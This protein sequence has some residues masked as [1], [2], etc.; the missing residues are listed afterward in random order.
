MQ[1]LLSTRLQGSAFTG[2]SLLVFCF[3]CV[4][5]CVGSNLSYADIYRWKDPQGTIH[6]SNTPPED[7]SQILDVIPTRRVPLVQDTEGTVYYLN[8]PDGKFTKD[9]SFQ[10]MLDQL[11]LPEDVLEGL[12]QEAAAAP[13]ND[14]EDENYTTLTF[15]MAEL[16][17]AL[18]REITKRLEWKQEYLKSQSYTQQLEQH[19]GELTLAMEQMELDIEKLQKAVNLSEIHL[20]ALRNPQQ[21]L[22]QLENKL[23]ELQ[24]SLIQRNSNDD[25]VALRDKLVQLQANVTDISQQT[26][27]YQDFSEQFNTLTQKI[28]RLEQQQQ[29]PD[30]RVSVK[31][32]GLETEVQQLAERLPTL[33]NTDMQEK[34]VLL[35]AYVTDIGQQTFQSVKTLDTTQADQ[36]QQVA[37]LSAKIS[38]LETEMKADDERQMY[39][40]LVSLS[41][42]VQKLQKQR[43]PQYD[44]SAIQRRL[45]QL[46]TAQTEEIEQLSTRNEHMQLKLAA[47]ET[48]IDG[49]TNDLPASQ[50]IST[51]ANSLI[52]RG[53]ALKTVT[54]DQAQQLRQHRSQIVQ[55]QIELGLLR[56]QSQDYPFVVPDSDL[57][58]EAS[59]ITEHEQTTFTALLEKNALMEEIINYQS[60]ALN[61]Q[62]DRIQRIE[63]KLEQVLNHQIPDEI[64]QQV[65]RKIESRGRIT[66]VERKFRR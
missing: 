7:S 52:E 25:V 24:T 53:N 48:E 18:E 37:A 57:S 4:L 64:V 23:V 22:G 28:E 35:Q 34:L 9:L 46:Q 1:P 21:K 62:K 58:T 44:D 63:T 11:T 29:Q 61:A 51:L 50:K 16:E 36:A 19:N 12:L 26:G 38:E 5:T 66:V 14:A 30:E 49:L 32:A 55:L 20:A 65:P 59:T 15:R 43:T 3:V 41:Q 27:D 33:E 31:L 54:A 40:Q 60:T 10:D 8:L 39:Q 47:L 56:T 6:Y 2:R 13:A 17:E 45:E 42:E